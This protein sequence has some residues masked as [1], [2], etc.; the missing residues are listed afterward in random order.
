MR[1]LT[2]TA[3]VLQMILR[4][5]NQ[6]YQQ[7]KWYFRWYFRV[8]RISNRVVKRMQVAFPPRNYSVVELNQVELTYYTL[9]IKDEA[10]EAT[11]DG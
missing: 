4:W 8:R 5:I 6:K 1:K 2:A 3:M 11:H 9:D 7:A 10:K